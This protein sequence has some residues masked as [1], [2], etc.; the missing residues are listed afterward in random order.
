M[1]LSGGFLNPAITLLLWV[2]NRLDTVRAS[3]LLGAQLVGAV[4]AGFCLSRT[5][6]PAL[7]SD[8]RLGTPHLNLIAYESIGVGS[9][10][11][12]AAI[13]LLLTFFLVL[14][15]FGSIVDKA[16]WRNDGTGPGTSAL[17][18]H[19]RFPGTEARLAALFGGLAMSA[20]VLVGYPLTGAAAN[21]ARWFGTVLWEATF[22]QA[23]PGDPGPFADTFVYVAG[24]V[25]G[26][27]LAGFVYFRLMAPADM[28]QPAQAGKPPEPQ[29]PA[30]TR[31]KR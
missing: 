20:C 23:R 8:A 21:P 7:L 13:E 30:P 9:V 4:L 29:R 19:G 2:F 31:G 6:D 26:A 25:L 28:D 14:G 5:F 1:H 27:L 10:A 11:S 15:I 12:G 16:E 17:V 22:I 18:Q 24:P 3:W